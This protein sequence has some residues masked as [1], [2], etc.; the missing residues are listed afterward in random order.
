MAPNLLKLFVRRLRRD[1]L[2]WVLII[3]LFCLL[4]LLYQL[5]EGQQYSKKHLASEYS[6]RSAESYDTLDMPAGYQDSELTVAVYRDGVIGNYEST[7]KLR[8]AFNRPGDH[9][10][11]YSVSG[12]DTQMNTYGMNMAVSDRIPM[13]R[14]VPDLRHAECPNWHYPEKLPT[15]TVVIVFHNEGFTTL[16]RTVHSVLLRSPRR[17]LR[18]VLLVDDY[19]D[20]SP[21]KI[22]LDRYMEDNFGPFQF[23]FNRSTGA[24]SLQGR[25]L[26]MIAFFHSPTNLFISF[27]T[28]ERLNEKSGKVRLLRNAERAGLIRSR[29]RGAR[30]ALG[31][32]V[33]FLDAHCEVNYNWLVP[34]LV[35]I[36][37]NRKTLTAPIIDGIDS[38][39][40]EYRPVYGAR[41][42]YMGIMEW[43]MLYKETEI[44]MKAHLEKHRFSEPYEAATHAGGLFAIARQFFLE[45]GGYDE[46][47]LVWGGEN[48]E[49]SFKVWQCGG[50]QLWVPCKLGRKLFIAM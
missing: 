17:H 20:R 47:L 43:G 29:A 19:S 33:V 42:H 37:E 49:L 44:D 34:L 35:P 12:V 7:R 18:E 38:D 32:V 5:P 23:D 45:L 27:F 28:G 1:R 30:E 40:F 13:D 4:Y 25:S 41:S 50:R 48:F 6:N 8:S 46:G 11:P 2:S 39:S 26:E 3:V 24:E 21:L 15:A 16:M 22:N 36:A 9:G 14:I 31:E 10:V